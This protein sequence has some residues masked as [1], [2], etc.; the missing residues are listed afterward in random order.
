MKP[1]K[2]TYLGKWAGFKAGDCVYIETEKQLA[3]AR[4]LVTRG[5]AELDRPDMQADKPKARLEAG[6]VQKD[7]KKM[8]AQKK[9]AA[10]LEAKACAEATAENPQPEPEAPKPKRRKRSL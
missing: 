3:A 5:M 8:A 4:V 1:I 10:E 2:L 9:A 6:V 7:A